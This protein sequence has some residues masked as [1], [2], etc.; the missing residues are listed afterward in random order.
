[1]TLFIRSTEGHPQE[2]EVTQSTRSQSRTSPEL[3][4]PWPIWRPWPIWCPWL[5]TQE[6]LRAH[7]RYSSPAGKLS[8]TDMQQQGSP[9]YPATPASTVAPTVDNG[10]VEIVDKPKPVLIVDQRPKQRERDHLGPHNPPSSTRLQQQS[11]WDHPGP[12]VQSSATTSS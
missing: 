12:H 8:N 4:Y 7:R 9:K 6:A 5:P 11:E 3:Q 1:M 2:E 10:T